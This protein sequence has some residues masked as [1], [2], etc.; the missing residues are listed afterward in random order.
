MQKRDY[1]EVLGVARN[2]DAAECKRAYRKLAMKYHPDRNPG[3]REAEEKFK[4]A[5]EAYRV[6]SDAEKRSQYD[7]F[8]HEGLSGNGGVNAS[9]FPDIFGDIFGDFFDLGRRGRSG[10]RRGND[11]QYELEL[12]FEEAVFGCSKEIQFPRV[13]PCD[14]CEGS[15]SMPGTSKRPCRGCGGRGQVHTRMMGLMM[16]QTCPHCRGAGQVIDRPCTDC[17]G[18]GRRRVTRNHR[19][20]IPAGIDDGNR[21]QLAGSGDVGSGGGPPGDLYVVIHVHQHEL[22]RREGADL[23]CTVPIS[24]AQAALGAEIKVPTL[25]GAEPYKVKAGTQPGAQFKLRGKGISRLH[26]GRRGDLYAQVE[27]RIPTKLTRDQRKLFER[28]QKVL[29]GE[30]REPHGGLLG[31]LH[32]GGR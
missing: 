14:S 22:F 23:H 24:V 2:A 28:L 17:S 12:N 25:E 19:I 10:A 26:S 4:E 15:G 7:Q 21:M 11:L 29:D 9:D 16:S 5:S 8:G 6:L 3:S 27:V 20:D 1:Y 32:L 31:K 13:E 30:E 18:E